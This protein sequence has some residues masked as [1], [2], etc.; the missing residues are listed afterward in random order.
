[1]NRFM[2]F[3]THNG[4]SQWNERTGRRVEVLRE[5][6]E[7]EADIADVGKM[8]CIRFEDGVETDA[9]EDELVD[10]MA[11][12]KAYSFDKISMRRKNEE[13]SKAIVSFDFNGSIFIR[14]VKR[15]RCQSI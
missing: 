6:T 14:R 13:I 9:F 11:A 8:F 12:V 4:D 1:M 10:P 5:L 15:K 2:T 3:D 7:A